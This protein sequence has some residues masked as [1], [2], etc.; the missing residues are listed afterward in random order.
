MNPLDHLT[1]Y[2]AEAA[3]RKLGVHKSTLI[4]WI[5]DGDLPGSFKANPNKENSPWRVPKK[6]VDAILKKRKSLA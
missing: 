2:S 6:A 5:N 4:D 1:T 3:A